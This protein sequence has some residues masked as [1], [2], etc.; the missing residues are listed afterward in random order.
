MSILSPLRARL[1]SFDHAYSV[2]SKRRAVTG[3][4]QFIVRTD[5]PLQPYRVTTSPPRREC[6]ITTMIA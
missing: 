3:R 1:A 6:Q 4:V 5:D 2:A